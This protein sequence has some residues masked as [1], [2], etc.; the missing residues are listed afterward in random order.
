MTTGADPALFSKR[1]HPFDSVLHGIQ[2][3]SSFA[4]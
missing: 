2:L 4:V 3:V 1:N